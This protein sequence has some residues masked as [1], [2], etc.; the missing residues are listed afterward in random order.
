MQVEDDAVSENSVTGYV[1]TKR[2]MIK[3]APF[4]FAIT[5]IGLSTCVVP[6]S[7]YSLLQSPSSSGKSFLRDLVSDKDG[8]VQA[9]GALP[10]IG[11]DKSINPTAARALQQTWTYGARKLIHPK[12]SDNFRKGDSLLVDGRVIEQQSV[13]QF[14]NCMLASES[15]PIYKIHPDLELF[16]SQIFG[17][18]VT[19]KAYHG[20]NTTLS[21]FDLFHGHLFRTIL[22]SEQSLIGILFHCAEYPAANTTNAATA[23]RDSS[24][25]SGL[26]L[27]YCQADSDCHPTLDDWRYRNVLWSA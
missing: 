19:S 15:S 7:C 4:L 20:C 22:S 12:Q 23:D 3:R 16:L 6:S 26:N 14:G 27:G 21:R 5:C 13:M 24:M 25:L 1:G 9:V 8:R 10:G 18:V 2:S 11:L 17:A